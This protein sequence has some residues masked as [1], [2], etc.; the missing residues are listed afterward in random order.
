MLIA[1]V[2]ELASPEVIEERCGVI[3]RLEDV[4]K[5]GTAILKAAA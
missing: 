3:N 2:R 4:V 1:K 5:R